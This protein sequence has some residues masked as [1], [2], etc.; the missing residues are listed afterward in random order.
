MRLLLEYRGKDSVVMEIATDGR[1]VR[2]SWPLIQIDICPE[3]ES[4]L[5]ELLGSTGRFLIEEGAG[6]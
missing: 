1:L 4:G 6:V 3:L 5:R 2:L